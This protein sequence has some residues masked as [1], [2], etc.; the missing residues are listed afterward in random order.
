MNT[1]KWMMGLTGLLT[2][3]AIASLA[4]VNHAQATAPSLPPGVLIQEH[5]SHHSGG[6]PASVIAQQQVMPGNQQFV[7]QHFIEMMIPHHEDAIAMADLA[8]TRAKHPELQKLAA[9]IKQDQTREINQMR[10]WYKQ[11]FAKDVPTVPTR[12]GMMGPGMMGGRGMM[13]N[14]HQMNHQPM[15][16]PSMMGMNPGRGMRMDLNALKTATDFDREFIRQMVPHHRMAVMMA[17]MLQ[18]RTTRPEMTTLAQAI[19][20]TQTAEIDQM[21]QWS[22][23]WNR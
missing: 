13:G 7:D 14:G 16:G 19:M 11:W 9:T 2:A 12:G 1:N 15:M 22:Q 18:N 20:K 17:Q 6:R 10:T 23:V 4:M 8:L 5:D 21:Q 3:G